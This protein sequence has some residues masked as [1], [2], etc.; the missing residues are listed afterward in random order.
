[1]PTL[2][3]TLKDLRYHLFYGALMRRGYELKNFGDPAGICQWKI[4][5]TWLNAQSIVY[6]AG[7][8]SDITFEHD[9]VRKFGCHVVLIDPSPTGLQTMAL[10]E[11]RISQF[12]FFPVALAGACRKLKM[13]APKPGEDA[14][15]PCDDTSAVMEV[16]A[17]NLQTL[18]R[19]NGHAQIDLLKLDIEGSEYEVIE[20]LLASGI[21]VRQI[22][23]EYHHEILPGIHRGQTIGSIFKLLRH[24]YRIL[25]GAA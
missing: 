25:P 13:A 16:P 7:V 9:L 17:E 12:H 2:S 24:R 14:W 18:M 1:M 5:P 20:D 23:V 6:S 8:G 15:R 10:P 4:C 21:K 3:R 22:C 19:R 11:N